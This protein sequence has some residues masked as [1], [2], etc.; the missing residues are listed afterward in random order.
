MLFTCTICKYGHRSTNVE[1]F[2]DYITRKHSYFCKTHLGHAKNIDTLVHIPWISD[3]I[4]DK[5]NFC[6]TYDSIIAYEN[7]C[8]SAAAMKSQSAVMYDPNAARNELLRGIN[9]I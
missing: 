5:G 9:K 4:N 7:Q 8:I 2:I 6:V 1:L 3:T